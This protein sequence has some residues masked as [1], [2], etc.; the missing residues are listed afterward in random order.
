[1]TGLKIACA[2]I[3]CTVGDIS[4]NAERIL[5]TARVARARG[6]DLLLTPEL[7]LVGYPPEDLLLRPDFY[8]TC[9]Q[10]LATLAARL[11]LAAVVGHP[12]LCADGSFNAASLLRGGRVEATYRKQRL[13]T[14]EIFDEA[15]YFSAG[16]APCVFEIA[17]VRCGINICADVW[18]PFPAAAARAAGAEMLLVLNA[19]PY[20]MDKQATRH[21]LLRQRGAETSM[22]SVYLQHGWRTG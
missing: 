16:T 5:A 2:Q 18:T 14:Y 22:P 9:A 6:A 19:S 13:P 1:M 7:A 8:R 17:G 21:A 12:E 20:H 10:E 3:N 15:R 4:G 11:P